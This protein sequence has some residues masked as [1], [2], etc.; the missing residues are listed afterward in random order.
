MLVIFGRWTPTHLL[1]YLNWVLELCKVLCS[2]SFVGLLP[3]KTFFLFLSHTSTNTLIQSFSFSYFCY[4]KQ[5]WSDTN[6]KGALKCLCVS[7]WGMLKAPHL[8]PRTSFT[9][10]QAFSN[11]FKYI[12]SCFPVSSHNFLLELPSFLNTGFNIIKNIIFS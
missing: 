2:K 4:F 7:K 1:T 11:I 3:T 9:Y 6:C 10:F 12:F 5:I 8:V